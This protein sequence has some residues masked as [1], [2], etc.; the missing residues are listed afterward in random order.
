MDK[1]GWC[2][3]EIKGEPVS[4][5]T[6]GSLSW[7]N[8][9]TED[10]WNGFSVDLCCYGCAWAFG[11][12]IHRLYGMTD[13]KELRSHLIEEHGLPHPPGK[14]GG[15]MSSDCMVAD[16]ARSLTSLFG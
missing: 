6:E 1:C 14:P 7:G 10:I 2:G 11:V 15:V 3:H 16:M 12:E 8:D 13:G 9:V 4:S 5:Y